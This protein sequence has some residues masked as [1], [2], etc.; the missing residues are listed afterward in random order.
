MRLHGLKSLQTNRYD[1]RAAP[2]V[3]QDGDQAPHMDEGEARYNEWVLAH[4]DPSDAP[5]SVMLAIMPGTRLRVFANGRWQILEPAVGDIVVFRG[6]VLHNGMGYPAEHLRIHA[7]LYPPGYNHPSEV[8]FQ[9]TPTG[10]GA[11]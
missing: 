9:E 5:M 8:E 10:P 7:Y 4:T 3:Q 6:N 1:T 11:S 2:E